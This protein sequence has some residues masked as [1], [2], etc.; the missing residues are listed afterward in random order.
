MVRSRGVTE[1][2]QLR[3]ATTADIHCLH[4]LSCHPAVYRYLFDGIAPDRE[5]VAGRVAQAVANIATQGLGMWLLTSHLAPCAGCIELRLYPLSQSAEVTY[6]LH[7][8]Y[9]RQGLATRMAWT[10][11]SQAFRSPHIDCVVAGHD[12]PNAAS[13]AVM[14]RLRHAVS[15]GRPV[16]AG[17]RRRIYPAPERSRTSTAA[18]SDTSALT[19]QACRDS[20][21]TYRR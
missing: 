17:N 7:P 21:S 2:W 16:S 12:L 3:P 9:C 15:S 1:S 18:G 14:R 11:I 13:L 5:F 4:T 20:S 10:A 8:D 19:T 6:F